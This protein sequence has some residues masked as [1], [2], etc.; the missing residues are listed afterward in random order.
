MKRLRLFYV[1][2]LLNLAIT[3]CHRKVVPVVPP[4]QAQ[5]PIIST[6]P[7]L[8]A[9]ALPSV[10]LASPIPAAQ[11]VAVAPPPPPP[12][13]KVRA[14]HHRPSKSGA[15]NGANATPEPAPAAS[16]SSP[17]GQLS[18]ED[19]NVNPK[20]AERTRRLIDAIHK[21][22]KRLPSSEQVARKDDIAAV[23]AFLAQAKQALNSN[24]LVGAETLV[25]KAKIV[26]DELVK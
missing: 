25:Q 9:P 14:H 13:K 6:M 18:A 19:T 22:L 3:G 16:G 4:P 15:T 24:D 12:T 20:Q 8:P 17:I 26:L 11:A 7:A 21:R 1:V 2:L 23:N 5:I 10:T